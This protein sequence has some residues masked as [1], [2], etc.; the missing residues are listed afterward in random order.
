MR[1]L[2]SLL[3][4]V[5]LG[6]AAQANL[7]VTK[8]AWTTLGSAGVTVLETMP[9]ASSGLPNGSESIRNRRGRSGNL[10]QLLNKVAKD[11]NVKPSDIEVRTF[12]YTVIAEMEDPQGWG[13][14]YYFPA[15]EHFWVLK[16]PVGRK[17]QLRLTDDEQKV[18]TRMGLGYQLLAV[19]YCTNMVRQSPGKPV[20]GYLWDCS[21][22]AIPRDLFVKEVITTLTETITV[23]NTETVYVDRPVYQQVQQ[24]LPYVQPAVP[25]W[26]GHAPSTWSSQP[27]LTGFWQWWQNQQCPKPTKTGGPPPPPISGGPGPI[28]TP[29]NNIENYDQNRRGG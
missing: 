25:N 22:W 4:L 9:Q 2:F 24:T 14:T 19:G 18:K 5:T 7:V 17:A 23:T 3:L 20:F 11:W 21:P 1:K 28:G 27:V 26:Y 16:N 15:G 29:P 13:R 6:V 10:D 12:P 8:D